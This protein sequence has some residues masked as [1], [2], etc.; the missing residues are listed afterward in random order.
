MK[1]ENFEDLTIQQIR[2]EILKF[3][4]DPISQKLANYYTSKSL[5]E[6]YGNSRKEISHS[7]FIGWLLDSNESHGLGGF[8][9]EK[10]LEILVIAS[11]SKH[12]EKHKQLF[13]SVISGDIVFSDT[14][15]VLEKALPG[16]GRL[17]IYIETFVK[18]S[19]SKFPLRIVIENKVQTKE[20][21]DQTSSY[22]E[23][24]ESIGDTEVNTLYVYL[25]V[26]SGVELSELQER[27][28]VECSSK[29]FIQ[30]NYQYLVDYLIEPVLSRELPEKIKFLI[31]DYLQSLSQPALSDDSGSL[32]Q[33]LVMAIGNE[34]RELLS[35][36]WEQNQKLILSAIYAISTDP[37]Q[38]LDT[39]DTANKLIREISQEGRD[40]SKIDI[41]LNGE[42]KVKDIIKA[43]IGLKT[44]KLIEGSGL[45]NDDSFD[46]FRNDFSCGF[47]LLKKSEEVTENEK[48]Y[49]KY[50]V[51]KAPE[52]IY[53]EEEYFVARNWG[54]TN[55]FNFVEACEKQFAELKFEVKQ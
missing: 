38:D 7:N 4:N 54:I 3:K 44:V 16:V 33:E 15:V 21:S 10:F 9:L 18:T 49:R 14:K 26:I 43:N 23:Y 29:E 39:K 12:Y 45:M 22:A 8:T 37:E 46:F 53:N 41:Y 34:E 52:F 28:E 48:K 1:H 5:A 30:I 42:L 19:N 17:D 11:H 25:T 2:N 31:K 40:R 35:K 32:K 51:H 6:I 50:R 13:D 27:E 47:L 55:I 24:F 20:H 36:F